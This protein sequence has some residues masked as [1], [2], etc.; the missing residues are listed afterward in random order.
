MPVNAFPPRERS[1]LKRGT[2]GHGG[3]SNGFNMAWEGAAGP[4][5]DP[6]G[7]YSIDLQTLRSDASNVPIASRLYP[8]RSAQGGICIGQMNA[9]GD[10]CAAIGHCN[11]A[12]YE[13]AMALGRYAHAYAPGMLA[14]GGGPFSTPG[15]CQYTLRAGLRAVTTDATPTDLV[16]RPQTVNPDGLTYWGWGDKTYFCNALIVGREVGGVNFAAF[17]RR[18]ILNQVGPTGSIVALQTI[19]TD[20]RSD[21]SWGVPSITADNTNNKLKI[22]V[23]GKAATTIRW[24][25]VVYAVELAFPYLWADQS[26]PYR[27]RIVVQTDY[28]QSGT[29]TDFPLY[30]PVPYSLHQGKLKAPAVSFYDPGGN[31]LPYDY[32]AVQSG[33]Q[34]HYHFWVK[35]TLKKPA[36]GND[37][38]L[39]MYYGAESGGANPDPASVWSAYDFVTHKYDVDNY[40]VAVAKPSILTGLKSDYDSP[41]QD[42]G[43]IGFGQRYHLQNLDYVNFGNS[44]GG[45]TDQNF[46]IDLWFKQVSADPWTQ[47]LAQR[48]RV[49]GQGQTDGWQLVLEGN[50]RIWLYLRD[51]GGATWMRSGTGQY[52]LN[53]WHHLVVEKIGSS[54]AIYLNGSPLTIEQDR[55]FGPLVSYAQRD[56]FTGGND[57]GSV[58]KGYIDEF[59]LIPTA[60]SQ[61]WVAFQYRNVVES[62][63][64]L[65]WG[66]EEAR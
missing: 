5:P 48:G 45:Y 57:E 24:H 41:I 38:M 1:L 26:Q 51:T 25:A 23:T 40:H 10:W 11:D 14:Y 20:Y 30:I 22:T 2:T 35:R 64:E 8:N 15:D 13:G 66:A 29:L 39:F 36:A 37:N 56:L 49:F 32:E 19:G 63:N 6:R 27:R 50:G 21:A 33:D 60:L 18:F 28:M 54:G 62:D 4:A 61:N 31:L 34:W 59:R 3:A 17:Q 55:S 9:A 52:A 46:S 42:E 16:N 65:T 58:F 43:R 7:E 44:V 47:T 53:Q 12:C